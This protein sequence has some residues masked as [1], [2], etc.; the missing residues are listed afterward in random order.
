MWPVRGSGVIIRV[1]PGN[2]QVGIPTIDAAGSEAE[3]RET[4]G[5]YKIKEVVKVPLVTI[6]QII[7]ENFPAY[8]DFLSIDIEGLDLEVLKSLDFN[9]YPIPVICIETCVYSEN[10]IRPKDLTIAEFI[11]PKGYE[12]YADTY[13]NTIF[14]KTDWFYKSK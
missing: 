2:V 6:N 9:K 3:K 8:P 1:S 5:T 12:V 13:I 11:I 4:S 7:K 14:V 10:H